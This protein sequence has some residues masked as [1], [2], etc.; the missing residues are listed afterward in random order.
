MVNTN[1]FGFADGVVIVVGVG[2]WRWNLVTNASN[3]IVM[4]VSGIAIAGS[5]ALQVAEFVIGA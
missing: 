4:F 5:E 3:E 2:Y 1:T